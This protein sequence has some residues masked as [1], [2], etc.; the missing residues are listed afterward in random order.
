MSRYRN[1]QL[2]ERSGVVLSIMPPKKSWRAIA[3]LSGGEKVSYSCLRWRPFR[4][5]IEL[6][7]GVSGSRIRAARLQGEVTSFDFRVKQVLNMLQPTPLYFMDEIDAA[8]DFKNVS[9]VAN[10]IQSK[11]QAAQL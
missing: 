9:I 1:K 4:L 2:A 5:T 8:L 6:D 10:Y 3:N 11:T 7:V